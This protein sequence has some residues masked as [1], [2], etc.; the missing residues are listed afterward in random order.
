MYRIKDTERYIF[1]G[2]RK[3]IKTYKPVFVGIIAALVTISLKG[4]LEEKYV[5]DI[6]ALLLAFIPAIYVG[7]ALMDGRRGVIVAEVVQAAVFFG[8]ALAGLW[9]STWYLVFG[10][11]AHGVWDLLHHSRGIQTKHPG[12]YVHFCFVYDW[13]ISLAL[14]VLILM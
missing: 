13:M 12:W 4:F 8:I 10:Y 3:S 11:F 1:K 6:S 9:G 2:G 5:F 14:V 7:F